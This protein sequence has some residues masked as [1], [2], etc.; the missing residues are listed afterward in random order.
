MNATQQ[1]T[2]V[3][4]GGW[5]L[6]AERSS[7][8][9]ERTGSSWTLTVYAKSPSGSNKVFSETASTLALAKRK[10]AD[11]LRLGVA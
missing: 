4:A 3:P 9:A 8:L 5:H 1:W 7:F 6:D 2:K 10:A 11:Y